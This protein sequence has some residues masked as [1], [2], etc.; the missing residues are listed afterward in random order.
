M[1]PSKK[2]KI[3]INID[4]IPLL[5]IIFIIL[6]ICNVISWS[7]LWVLCPLWI[8]LAFLTVILIIIGISYLIILGID[9]WV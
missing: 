5:C 6:K 3:T 1:E 7:W 2:T 4:I 8:P 9:E